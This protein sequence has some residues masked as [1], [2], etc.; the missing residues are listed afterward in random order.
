MKSG[1]LSYIKAVKKACLIAAVLLLIAAMTLFVFA[2]AGNKLLFI[3][4]ALAAAAVLAL[5]LFY[6]VRIKYALVYELSVDSG[7]VNVKV[8]GGPYAF[9]PEHV[10]RVRYNERKFLVYISRGGVNER[11]VLLRRVPF[12]RFRREQFS[13]ADVASFFPRIAEGVK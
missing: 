12:D 3:P 8:K 10:V 9:S 6:L 4:F 5:F 11:F 2:V 13:L 1:I 7:V